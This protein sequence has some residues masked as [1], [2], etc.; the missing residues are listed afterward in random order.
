M[1]QNFI[2][3]FPEMVNAIFTILD[4]K[5]ILN[6]QEV[7]REWNN[8]LCNTKFLSMRKIRKKL[9]NNHHKFTG[10][11]R[12]VDKNISTQNI[13]EL[14]DAVTKYFTDEFEC[15]CDSGSQEP[16]FGQGN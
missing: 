12:N 8:F 16:D 4:T 2:L 14:E 5:N 15:D 3:R 10:S 7:S 11:W 13:I 6:C 1:D 9:E